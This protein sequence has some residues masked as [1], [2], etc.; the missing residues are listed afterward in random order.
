VQSKLSTRTP[1]GPDQ[2]DPGGRTGR[3]GRASGA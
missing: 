1:L 2:S 3:N